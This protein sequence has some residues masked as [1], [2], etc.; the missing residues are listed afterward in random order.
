[1]K[2][3]TM[4]ALSAF[5]AEL[6]YF[7]VLG[8]FGS[9]ATLMQYKRVTNFSLPSSIDTPSSF[10]CRQLF[11]RQ[12]QRYRQPT[13]LAATG[14]YGH[15]IS[16][17]LSVLNDGWSNYL[18]DECIQNGFR[19]FG[20]WSEKPTIGLFYFYAMCRHSVVNICLSISFEKVSYSWYS[21]SGFLDWK[22]SQR[23]LSIRSVS[24]IGRKFN[25]KALCYTNILLVRQRTE[26]RHGNLR[27]RRCK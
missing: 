13:L 3:K 23:E 9:L 15:P 19:C 27:C 25:E 8:N 4:L 6:I 14:R 22:M 18:P 7:L 21:A 16:I 20:S 24:Q 12:L 11:C 26:S 1:M 5:G 2:G 17:S 10:Y